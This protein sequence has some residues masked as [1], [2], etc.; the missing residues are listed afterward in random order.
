MRRVVFI[1]GVPLNV[2]PV[3]E[4]RHLCDIADIEDAEYEDITKGDDDEIEK[5]N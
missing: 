3:P 1:N 2:W 5:D 4:Y